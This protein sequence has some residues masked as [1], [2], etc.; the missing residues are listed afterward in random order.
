MSY[1]V[2]ARKWRPQ[3]FDQLVGQSHISTTLQNALKNQR[4]PHA[5]LFT[6]P[7]GTGKTS[8][9]RILA[10]ALRCP[11]AENFI[12]CGK[13]TE[14]EEIALSRSPNV[15]EIDGASNNGVDAIRELRDTVAYA[16]SSGKYKIYIID[17]VHML[18]T[19]AFN[20]LLKTLEEPP[21]HVIFIMATTEAHKI[22]QTILSRCQRFDFRR[23]PTRQIT[24]RLRLICQ[25]DGI[26]AE[27]DALWMVARQ[28]DG[29]M[30]D[31]QSLLDQVVT[32]ANGPLTKENVVSILGLTDR[33]LL[34]EVL[35]GLIQRDSALILA[36][37]KKI[38]VA[39][40]EPHLFVNDLLE[41]IRHLLLMKV[42]A[43]QSSEIIELPDS[44]LRYLGDLCL[45]VSEED[46]H[47]L[48]DMALK[49]ASEIPRA[50]EPMIVLEMLLLRMASAPKIVD[51]QSLLKGEKLERPAVEAKPAPSPV[52]AKPAPAA[53][54]KPINSGLSMNPNEKWFELVQAL[55]SKDSLLGAKIENL[56]FLG[57]KN[58]TIEL[59]VPTKMSFLRDLMNDPAVREKV[60]GLIDQMWG[61]G[62]ALTVRIAQETTGASSAK[63]IEQEKETKR[64]TDLTQ[65]MAAHPKVK[66]A[67]AIFKGQIKSIK[68]ST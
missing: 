1:Q 39:G 21:E 2:I 40:Y 22:P 43:E 29:S 44:E 36:S 53:V 34:L 15:L 51:L 23:I 61:P 27:D 65:Q 10:K 18:S 3:N 9:A 56:L 30:R 64:Q 5:I 54:K 58:K 62:Y 25:T 16:P 4:L 50:S 31:S 48:F 47:M 68:E 32:F 55:R 66:A 45:H 37:L 33:A 6:G 19:S 20:A 11:N 63:A 24:E 7:R 12:P 67:N 59:G 52:L 41:N 38:S 17:E 28:G 14:C 46:I 8:S 13:C 60:Q 42:S 49:G 57:D 35:A 26:V